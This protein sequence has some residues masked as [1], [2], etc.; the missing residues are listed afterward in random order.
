MGAA[1]RSAVKAEVEVVRLNP[2]CS[3]CGDA[4]ATHK[5]GLFII[6]REIEVGQFCEECVVVHCERL[7]KA[8]EGEE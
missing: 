8:L 5:L 7:D 6:G 1:V 2:I 3:G 4:P